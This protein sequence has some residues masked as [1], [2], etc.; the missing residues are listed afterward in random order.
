MRTTLT[1]ADDVFLIAKQHAAREHVSL[2]EALSSLVR[3]S[4][5][6]HANLSNPSGVL[7]SKYS[8]LSSR[9]EIVTNAHVRRLMDEEGI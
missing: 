4:F 9:D 8:V 6:K 7:N 2:G 5:N 3:A 1:L